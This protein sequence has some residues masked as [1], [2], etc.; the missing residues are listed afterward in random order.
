MKGSNCIHIYK[1]LTAVTSRF[2][3]LTTLPTQKS[4]D[5]ALSR[6]WFKTSD[7]I[8]IIYYTYGVTVKIYSVIFTKKIITYFFFTFLYKKHNNLMKE[9]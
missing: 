6:D 7:I 2:A 3:T 5:D 9:N 1:L 4:R 8:A